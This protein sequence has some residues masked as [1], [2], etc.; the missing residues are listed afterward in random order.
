MPRT[1]VPISSSIFFLLA[2]HAANAQSTHA[3]VIHG[4]GET[5]QAIGYLDRALERQ[6]ATFFAHWNNDDYNAATQWA[7]ACVRP[8]YEF[9]GAGRAARLRAYQAKVNQASAQQ[10]AAE[11]SAR[12]KSESEHAVLAR[13]Q[14]EEADREAA[15]EAVLAR[16]KAATDA[17]RRAKA[18]ADAA[19]RKGDDYR[20][21]KAQQRLRADLDE[22]DRLNGVLSREEQI[23]ERSG[24]KNLSLDYDLGERLV[25]I[26]EAIEKDW[27]RYSEA[28]GVSRPGSG[29]HSVDNPCAIEATNSD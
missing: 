11:T 26:D 14:A 6:D 21:Y 27:G 10:L 9:V 1:A 20:V 5:C 24:V 4:L 8:G 3:Y 7:T 16:S 12:E 13:Q 28:G 19:C 18:V 15:K 23:E 2:F 29:L 22:R 17:K 25:T